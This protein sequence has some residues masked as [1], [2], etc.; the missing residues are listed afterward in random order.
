MFLSELLQQA[1]YQQLMTM[2]MKKILQV[3]MLTKLVQDAGELG[4][5]AVDAH[6]HHHLIT[7]VLGPVRLRW[8]FLCAWP[9]RRVGTHLLYVYIFN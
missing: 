7:W 4:H 9:C 8:I 2:S 1:T 3:T 5:G 6:G